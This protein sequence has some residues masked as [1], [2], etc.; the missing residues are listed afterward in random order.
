MDIYIYMD[1]LIC[2]HLP[3]RTAARGGHARAQVFPGA[4]VRLVPRHDPAPPLA[5][6]LQAGGAEGC[7]DKVATKSME[8]RRDI[9]EK[10]PADCA[11]AAW[12]K[13]CWR[14]LLTPEVCRAPPDVSRA[15]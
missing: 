2:M 11:L 12:S 15:S 4:W 13:E 10:C 5:C 6:T 9:R 14:D 8:F 1:L 3:R 7:R